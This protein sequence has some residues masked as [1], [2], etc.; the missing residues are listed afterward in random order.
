MRYKVPK[1]AK[2]VD[3][4]CIRE[5][6]GIPRTQ[7]FEL[8]FFLEVELIDICAQKKFQLDRSKYS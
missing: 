6:H 5:I 4:A 8:K 2:I 7:P 3:F 1:L